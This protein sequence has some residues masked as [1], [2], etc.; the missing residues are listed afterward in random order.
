MSPP[1]TK[2]CVTPNWLDRFSRWGNID[3]SYIPTMFQW[4]KERLIKVTPNCQQK[5]IAWFFSFF[6]TKACSYLVYMVLYNEFI[7]LPCHLYDFYIFTNKTVHYTRW[8]IFILIN[9]TPFYGTCVQLMFRYCKD[10]YVDLLL[11]R[12]QCYTPA[13]SHFWSRK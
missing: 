4:W 9:F 11:M 5:L 8:W 12:I 3:H 2:M 1:Y 13:V 6:L 10:E 7:L